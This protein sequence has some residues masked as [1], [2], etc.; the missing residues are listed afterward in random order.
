MRGRRWRIVAGMVAAALALPA[1]ASAD[2]TVPTDPPRP[3]DAS[4]PAQDFNGTFDAALAGLVRADP[5]RGP[6]GTTAIRVR[7]C[8]DQPPSGGGNTLDIGVYEPLRARRHRLR[9]RRAARVEWQRGQGPGDL[10]QRLLAAGH[11]RTRT[12]RRSCTAT[13][14]APTSPARSRPA[15]GRSSSASPRSSARPPIPDGIDW[16]VRVETSDSRRVVRLAVLARPVRL[17]PARRP[18]FGWYSGDVHVHGEEEPGNSLMTD[19]VRL[20]LRPARPGR[21]RARLRRA[22]R[23]QQQRQHGRDRPLPARLPRQ[24]DHPGDRGHHLQGPLQQHRLELVRRLPR[25][26]GL[27]LESPHAGRSPR[28]PTG[29]RR[30]AQFGPIQA[31]GGWT[32][33]NHP[34][35]IG[36]S[37]C[38]GCPWDYTDAETD[39]SK[40]D[41]IEVQNG[42]ADFGPPPNTV[43]SPFTATAIAFYERALASGAHVAAVGSSDAHQTDDPGATIGQA[44]TVVGA[45]DLSRSAIVQGIRD[46]RTYVKLYG[47]DGP[48][49]R[50]TARVAGRRP[51]TTLGDT[52]AG[53]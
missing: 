39:Y 27:P 20:R 17:D 37:I 2:C 38:R 34:T 25:R 48:D 51:F 23:P 24:A 40:V 12:A 31:S 46:D 5:V 11:L 21:R 42:A 6:A 50:V 44:T 33:I 18:G 8:Y 13:R 43:A 9:P 10:G 26:P 36:G 30:R 47:N 4:T 22:R 53:P 1:V 16:R 49:I 7:Y 28:S 32:Q 19:L 29:S 45:G 3:I 41:A 15:P 14:P 52:L 35:V